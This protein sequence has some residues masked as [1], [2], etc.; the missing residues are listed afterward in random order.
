MTICY[1]GLGSNLGSPQR[2][3]MLALTKLNKLPKSVLTKTSKCYCSQ[4]AGSRAQPN[5]Y[6]LVV[7]L[8][9]SLSPA[10]LLRFCQRIEKQHGRVRRKKWGARTLDVDILIYGKRQMHTRQL[11]IPHPRM[12]QRDFVLIPLLSITPQASLPNSTLISTHLEK[13]KRYIIREKS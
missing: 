10:E 2:Q 13:C 1:L 8:S 4:V 7:E 9:T 5:Y 12:L 3:L 11:T 6:N